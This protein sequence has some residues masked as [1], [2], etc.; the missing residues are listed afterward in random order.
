M[1]ATRPI[2]AKDITS[3]MNRLG[4]SR[5]T[6][7]Y[8]QIHSL[9]RPNRR[10]IEST[11]EGYVVTAKGKALLTSWPG[12]ALPPKSSAAPSFPP[13]V[14]TLQPVVE[15]AFVPTGSD[16]RSGVVREVKL[17]QGQPKFRQDLIVRY[18]PRCMISGCGSLEAIE[19]AHIH[20]FRGKEDNH[21]DNGLL[22]RADLHNLF[23]L[24]LI[25][26]EPDTL[27]VRIHPSVRADYGVFDGS[28][29]RVPNPPRPSRQALDVHHRRFLA[30]L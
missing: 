25:S 30:G 2:R 7:I 1:R 24:D 9:T 10:Y 11:E 21:L 18:G 16:D 14:P 4:Y 26:I 8:G 3:E 5:R 27:K 19:A 29:L 12:Q 15:P 23:D 28:R 13:A 20:A 17:R 6:N 22:L